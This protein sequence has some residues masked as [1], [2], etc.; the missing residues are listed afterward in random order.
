ML[1]NAFLH[2]LGSYFKLIFSSYFIC[3]VSDQGFLFFCFVFDRTCQGNPQ[4]RNWWLRI[5]MEVNGVS[6]TYSEVIPEI[7][8]NFLQNQQ[9]MSFH[10]S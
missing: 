3:N 9:I 4:H 7:Q 5:Y 10:V 6:G 1:M 2:W 8:F